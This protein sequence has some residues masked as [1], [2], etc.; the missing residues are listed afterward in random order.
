[1][2]KLGIDVSTWQGNVDWE[3]VKAAGVEFAILRCGYV[4]DITEQDDNTFD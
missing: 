2:K 1:M 4:M 3:K